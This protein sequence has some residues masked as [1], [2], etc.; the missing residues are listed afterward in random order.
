M[1]VPASESM[2]DRATFAKR[3]RFLAKMMCLP[4][5]PYVANVPETFIPIRGSFL[6]V[7][8][9]VLSFQEI[10]TYQGQQYQVVISFEGCMDPAPCYKPQSNSSERQNGTS[11]NTSVE[12]CSFVIFRMLSHIQNFLNA[13]GR[14]FTIRLNQICNAIFHDW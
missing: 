1:S 4:I 12:I 7:S 14:H 9:A 10:Y 2:T 13:Q 11:G 8:D 3:A 6:R 5:P